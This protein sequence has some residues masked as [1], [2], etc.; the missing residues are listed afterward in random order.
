MPEVYQVALLFGV[1]AVAGVI[2][3]MAG[4]GSSLTLPVLIFLGLDAA[5]A[6]GTNRIAIVIQ[7]IS[8]TASFRKLKVSRLRQSAIFAGLAVPGAIA[9]AILA[10]SISNEWFER[11]L[12]VVIIGVVVSMLISRSGQRETTPEGTPSIWIYPVMFGI[13]FYGGFI[14]VGVGFLLMAALYHL[15]RLD[16]LFVNMHKVAIVLIYSIPA[17]AIF[18]I[19]DNVAWVLGLSLAA[20]NATGGWWAAHFSVKRG[21]KAIRYVLVVALVIMAAKL[22]GAF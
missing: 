18:V 7:N 12:A 2:N 13:G 10:V 19:S 16:L 8:A 21:E 9:G 11:I 22:F 5:T 3:V 20:G 1:G 14:Q 15:L 17:L 4:G 6:N